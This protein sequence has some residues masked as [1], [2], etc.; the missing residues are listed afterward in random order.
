MGVLIHGRGAL[1][2]ALFGGVVVVGELGGETLN[3]AEMSEVVG[4]VGVRTGR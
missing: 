2:D 1:G 3:L 4:D